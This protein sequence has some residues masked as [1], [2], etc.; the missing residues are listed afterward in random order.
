M[1]LPV[2][3]DTYYLT[4]LRKANEAIAVE[5]AVPLNV[6]FPQG[7]SGTSDVY[8]TVNL[9][10]WKNKIQQEIM[11]WRLDNNYVPVLPLPIGHQSIGGDGKALLLTQEYRVWIEIITA[12]MGVPQEFLMGGLSFSGSNVS[13]RMLEN[14]FLDQNTD[15]LHLIN[16]HQVLQRVLFPVY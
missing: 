8:S 3:K 14:Q 5:R 6:I 9:S 1:I 16:L 10:S 2:L 13:L 7:A 11:R 12:G 4:I 15:H